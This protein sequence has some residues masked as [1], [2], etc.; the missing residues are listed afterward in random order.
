M[1]F[2]NL[3]VGEL[4]RQ[5]LAN[6]L[7]L[8]ALLLCELGAAGVG[9]DLLRLLALLNHLGEQLEQLRVGRLRLAGSTRGDVAILYRRAHEP[10][11]RD[12]ALVLRLGA[13][14]QGSGRWSRAWI[15]GQTFLEGS[16]QGNGG[17]EW[18]Q[19]ISLV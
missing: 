10:E 18:R 7:D 1:A 12:A 19:G 4:L 16:V 6:D 5:E 8:L 3:F 9:I 13:V 11:R 14:L 15:S 2:S 17:K